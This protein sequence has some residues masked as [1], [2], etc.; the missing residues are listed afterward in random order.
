MKITQILKSGGARNLYP[1]DAWSTMGGAYANAKNWKRNAA[2]C[3]VGVTSV[4]VY[5][6]G[7][8]YKYLDNNEENIKRRIPSLRFVNFY[9]FEEHRYDQLSHHHKNPVPNAEL[10]QLV[11]K[12]KKNVYK[13]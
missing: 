13:L 10:E 11:A 4:I 9:N 8:L 3:I 12:T 1:K 5:V 7:V 2:L 6:Q